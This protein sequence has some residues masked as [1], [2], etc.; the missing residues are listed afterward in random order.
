MNAQSLCER[1][2]AI[3]EDEALY[4][5]C[6]LSDSAGFFST[7]RKLLYIVRDEEN[8]LH[9][10]IETE[11]LVLHTH[12]RI[13]AVKNAATFPDDDY[14]VLLY[15]GS[16]DDPN[17]ESFVQLCNI[18]A[19]ESNSLRFREF[20][21]SLIDLFKL[22]TEQEYKNAVGLYGELKLMQIAFEKYNTDI[23]EMWH[24]S[25]SYSRFDFSSPQFSIEVKA[26]AGND[27][28][29]MIKH[30]QV[31]EDTPCVLA[32]INCE[33]MDTGE[34]LADLISAL[35]HTE[36]AFQGI[37]FA[38]NIAVEQKRI[39]KSD[40]SNLRFRIIKLGLYKANEINPFT[41]TPSNVSDLS[42]RLDLSDAAPLPESLYLSVFQYLIQ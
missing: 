23:S 37:N 41:S 34:S 21:Y 12:I 16:A 32:V 38:I 20:F 33:Q 18:H 31:F 27:V 14:N 22:P 6:A 25:G 35:Q 2:A 30:Q 40:F 19:R 1:I 42:Y 36:S 39:S 15:K 26:I 13:S 7:K 3:E 17:M 29:V 11:F 10:S 9:E 24:K 4:L 8:N 28:T 5:L